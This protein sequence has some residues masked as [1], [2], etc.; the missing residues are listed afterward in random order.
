[1]NTFVIKFVL[2]GIAFSIVKE[3]SCDLDFWYDNDDEL[4]DIEKRQNWDAFQR[5]HVVKAPTT[6]H[7]DAFWDHTAKQRLDGQYGA[8]G[9]KKQTFI[10][11][12]K[13]SDIENNFHGTKC[14]IPPK[15]FEGIRKPYEKSRDRFDIV[16]LVWDEDNG[17]YAVNYPPPVHVCVALDNLDRPVHYAGKEA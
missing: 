1:M 10:R 5:K 2:V 3:I 9:H 12:D 15:P 7:D 14:R 11:V 16:E 8:P 17:N 4:Y 13:E 6:E